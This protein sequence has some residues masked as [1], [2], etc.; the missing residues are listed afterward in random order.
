MFSETSV[1]IRATGCNIP[2][3]IIIILAVRI[4]VL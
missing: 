1:I 4:S 2:E 3:D